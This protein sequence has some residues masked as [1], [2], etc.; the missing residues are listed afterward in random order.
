M[1]TEPA[2]TCSRNDSTSWPAVVPST[3]PETEIT[4]TCERL[5]TRI[6]MRTS[7]VALAGRDPRNSLGEGEP[8][9]AARIGFVV[10]LVHHLADQVPAELSGPALPPV[11]CQVRGR[12]A[13]WRDRKST[14]LNSS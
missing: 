2:W 12:R 10:Y 14:R 4:V 13:R 3:L 6:S 5:S 8:V 11:G 1:Q 7:S 9:S